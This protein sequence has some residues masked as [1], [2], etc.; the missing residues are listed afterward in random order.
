MVKVGFDNEKYVQLQSER[1][2]ERIASF[3]NKLYL[4]MGG[5][6][7]DD[8]H[9]SRV[10]LGFEPDSKIKMLANLKDKLELVI[11]ISAGDIVNNK[12]RSDYNISYSAD[13]VR[14]INSFRDSGFYV[15]SVVITRY[16]GEKAAAVFKAHLEDMGIKVY[17]HYPIEGYPSS[18]ELIV[19]DDGYGKNDYIETSRPLVVVT[20]PGPGSGKMAVC[21]SQLYHEH[22]RGVEAG[23][24]KF[25]TFP[26]WNLSINHPVNLAYEAA[27]AD[28]YDV[29][30]IDPYHLDAYGVKTVNYNRDIDAFPLLDTIFKRILGR[31]PY[32]SPTDMGVNMAGSCI[33]DDEAV[34][35]AA[36]DEIVRRYYNICCDCYNGRV[37]KEAVYKVELILNK[38]NLSKND[39]AVARAARDKAQ[40]CGADSAAIE[41]G[42]GKIIKGKSGGLLNA[43]SAV[44]INAL[45]Y[46]SGIEKEKKLISPEILEPIHDLKAIYLTGN[47]EALNL[48]ETLIAL[49]VCSKTDSA[50][51]RAFKMLPMLKNSEAHCT[52]IPDFSDGAVYKK[53]GINMTSDID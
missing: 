48:E 13:V 12:I 49:S 34:R 17:L 43:S 51:S 5:K 28:L 21:L 2:K 8:F 7:F 6:L 35:K 37:E 38:A 22:K 30:M 3:G 36:C 50:A 46:L 20:A 42:D 18:V 25:E 9:A 19:S 15:G 1:I 33:I 40:R 29:N 45:K 32:K 16:C 47:G 53:L 27:T 14:L 23:Y 31:S 44:L 24:A 4:E 26:I 39:R 11:A 41:L 52:H 10:L